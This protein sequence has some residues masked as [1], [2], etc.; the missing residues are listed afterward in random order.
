M[1]FIQ[2]LTQYVLDKLGGFTIDGWILRTDIK[3]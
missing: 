1:K 3:K 2:E